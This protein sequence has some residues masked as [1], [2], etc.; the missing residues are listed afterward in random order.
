MKDLELLKQKYPN[1]WQR[2]QDEKLF[3]AFIRAKEKQKQVQQKLQAKNERERKRRARALIILAELCLQD[4]FLLEKIE[5][6][7]AV[8]YWQNQLKVKERKQTIDL[9][10]YITSEI[11]RIK[12]NQA[13]NQAE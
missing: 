9:A 2:I 8:P 3:L 13:S 6:R 11:E 10:P 7:L 12:Q 5:K 1:E 4:S